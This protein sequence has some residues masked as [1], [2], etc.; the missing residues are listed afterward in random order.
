MKD[1]VRTFLLG[2]ALS[3]LAGGAI[4]KQV[5]NLHCDTTKCAFDEEL[6]PS[7]TKTF[8]GYCD[9]YTNTKYNSNM[10]CHAVKGMTCSELIFLDKHWQCMCTNWETKEQHTTIDVYCQDPNE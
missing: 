6:G 7:Q 3:V 2:G 8:N 10:V 1:L 5:E 4:A 9:G